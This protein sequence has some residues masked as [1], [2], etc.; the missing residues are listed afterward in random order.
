MDRKQKYAAIVL[1]LAFLFP[2]ALGFAETSG[3]SLF[4][5]GN[6]V[7]EINRAYALLPQTQTPRPMHLLHLDSILYFSSAQWSVWLQGKKWTPDMRD[8]RITIQEVGRDYIRLKALLQNG[9]MVEIA[10]LELNQSL[11]LLTGEIQ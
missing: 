8:D 11:N 7:N 4:F 5:T 10:R 6:E 1:T 9:R 2:P 3:P